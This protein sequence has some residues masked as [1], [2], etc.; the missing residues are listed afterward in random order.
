MSARHPI[1][2][3]TGSS[4]AGTTT[5][6]QT[7]EQIFWRE[8]VNAPSSSRGDSFH[9]FTRAE[10]IRQT[11]AADR[12]ASRHRRTSALRGNDFEGIEALF[13][14]LCRETAASFCHYIHDEVEAAKFGGEIGGFS[15][16]EEIP[17]RHRPVVFTKGR[18]GAVQTETTVDS[19]AKY[20]D[21]LIGVV[22]II[23]LE[24][25]QKLHRDMNLRGYSREA[26]TTTILR[27]M[28]DYVRP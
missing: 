20:S 10:M 14:G 13:K 24:W 5:V 15:A 18:N 3:V 1:I 22:P 11:A 4:G 7:F 9:R 17:G 25:I 26:V 23:N 6:T 12:D 8:Y 21:L 2:A 28:H 27:R 19:L 16:F